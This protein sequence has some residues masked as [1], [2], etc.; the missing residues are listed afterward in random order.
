MQCQ[1]GI[2]AP[3]IRVNHSPARFRKAMSSSLSFNSSALAKLST[4]FYFPCHRTGG[5]A[6]FADSLFKI[7]LKPIT[8]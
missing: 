3:G 2:D 8:F 7:N 5:M 4:S 1:A 6:R